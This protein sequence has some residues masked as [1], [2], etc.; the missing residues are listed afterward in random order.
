MKS[1]SV[2]KLIFWDLDG[3]IMHC[4]ADGTMALNDAFRKLYGMEDVFLGAGIGHSMDSVILERIREN[5]KLSNSDI[6]KAK[7]EYVRTLQ[8]ILR[9]NQNKKV[10]PGIRE[11]LK[12]IDMSENSYNAMLTSNLRIGAKAKLESVGLQHYF[13]VG[14]FGDVYGEKADAAIK[15]I[16][17]AESYYGV[18]FEKKHIY[19]VGDSIYDIACAREIDAISIGVAT[20]F[21]DYDV[22]KSNAPDY[23]YSDLSDWKHLIQQHKWF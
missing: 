17:E 7:E 3:T 14:G 4:G 8:E 16:E 10:L 6:E 23:F 1:E 22:L 12:H 21:T 2:K 11:I 15:G 18:R 5:Y 19:I 20:G 9:Q 13:S